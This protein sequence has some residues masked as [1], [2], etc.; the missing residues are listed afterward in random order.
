MQFDKDMQSP[1]RT[2]FMKIREFILNFENIQEIKKQRITTYLC[3]GSGVCHLRTMPHGVDIGLVKGA[4][5]RD[6]YGML[7]GS[8]KRIRVLS[9][10]SMLQGE[11]RYYI[12]EAI[13]QTKNS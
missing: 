13:Q 5:I 2:L 6:K 10:T 9:V 7:Y 3:N 12:Q 8:S 1:Y 11:L 4:F